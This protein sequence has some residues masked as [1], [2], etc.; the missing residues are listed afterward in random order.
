VNR[1]LSTKIR[2]WACLL[3]WL[4][5]FFITWPWQIKKACQ[6]FDT[7]FSFGA[8]IQPDEQ[9]LAMQNHRTED[10]IKRISPN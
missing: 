5:W 8:D 1:K 2:N 10:I 6:Q 7:L 4:P 9:A 3:V